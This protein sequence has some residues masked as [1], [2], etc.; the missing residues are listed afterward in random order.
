MQEQYGTRQRALD[1]YNKFIALEP[2]Y[3]YGYSS[4]ADLELRTGSLLGAY[5]DCN[6]AIEL[7]PQN[8]RAYFTRG[9]LRQKLFDQ[10]PAPSKTTKNHCY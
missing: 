2:H 7:D 1:D 4:K 6:K 10:A 3:S 5:L 9:Q 8:G